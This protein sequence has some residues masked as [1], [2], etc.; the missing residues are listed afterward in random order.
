M[1]REFFRLLNYVFFF[2]DDYVQSKCYWH[3]CAACNCHTCITLLSFWPTQKKQLFIK[4]VNLCHYFDYI[5]HI[6]RLNIII[7]ICPLG[8]L[9][10]I[11][12]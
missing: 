2:K 8:I 11:F 9:A 1:F 10:Y 3:G 6:L 7:A 4:N 5:N 12:K